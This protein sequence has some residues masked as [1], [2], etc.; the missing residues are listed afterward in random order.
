MELVPRGSSMFQTMRTSF[1]AATT[2]I[3]IVELGPHSEALTLEV[4][5]LVPEWSSFYVGKIYV[6]FTY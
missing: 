1:P 2:D 3:D 5:V 6:L 4:K